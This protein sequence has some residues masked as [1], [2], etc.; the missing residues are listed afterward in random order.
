MGGTGVN[1]ENTISSNVKFD[2][3]LPRLNLGVD[4][5]LAFLEAMD[6]HRMTYKANKVL[7]GKLRESF[8]VDVEIV[9]HPT[10]GLV[11]FQSPPRGQTLV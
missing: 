4:V 11:A 10:N 7:P 1:I 2:W 5:G 9:G 6:R 8:A 3:L